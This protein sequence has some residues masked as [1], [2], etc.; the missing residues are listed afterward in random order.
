MQLKLHELNSHFKTD[1]APVYLFHGAEPLLIEDSANLLRQVLKQKGFAERIIFTMEAG[2]D[3]PRF[4]GEFDSMSLFAQQKLIEL[5]LPTGKPGTKGAEI[6]AEIAANSVADTVLLILAGKLE[7]GVKNTKWVK[8]ISQ[9]GVMVEHYAVLPNQL[10]SWISNRARHYQLSINN[11][12]SRLL[13]YYLEGNLL[14][15]DQELKKFALVSEGESVTI[16]MIQQGV[17]DSARFSIYAL[18]DSAI[19]G[20]LRRAL[21]MLTS[22]RS[23]GTEPVLINWALARETRSL[24][25]MSSDIDQGKHIS[26]VLKQYRVW[27]NRAGIVES[28]LR[29]LTVAQWRQVHRRAATMDRMIKGRESTTMKADIWTEYERI[30]ACLCG[31][32][33]TC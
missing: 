23:E 11:D 3:W 7:A 9:H 2:F 32:T 24:L 27:N 20:N 10:L 30:I 12:A 14:A 1:L 13:A 8:S 4:A 5:R 16:Q 19:A 22:L 21:R 28:A 25:E 29:R 17:E 15:I 18:I 26:Q 31:V 6:L 33:T